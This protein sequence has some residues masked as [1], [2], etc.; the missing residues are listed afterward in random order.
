MN[1]IRYASRNL[2]I[3]DNLFLMAICIAGLLIVF[4]IVFFS[5]MYTNKKK[6]KILMNCLTNSSDVSSSFQYKGHY[7]DR[8]IYM[9]LIDNL[10]NNP[11]TSLDYLKAQL[12]KAENLLSDPNNNSKAE[13]DVEILS[14]II[15]DKESRGD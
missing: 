3:A 7:Y 6:K 2:S 15:K 11:K 5:V 14:N 1:A 13:V 4:I 9:D 10:Y 12:K 8:K